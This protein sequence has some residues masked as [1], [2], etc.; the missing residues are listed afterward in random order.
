MLKLHALTYTEGNDQQAHLEL[1]HKNPDILERVL[2]RIALS[3]S[4]AGK[5]THMHV[6]KQLEHGRTSTTEEQ[7]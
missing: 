3:N 6:I 4:T 5:C 1:C 7:K 2:N